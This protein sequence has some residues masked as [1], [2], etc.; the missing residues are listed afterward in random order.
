MLK[1]RACYVLVS[2]CVRQVGCADEQKRLNL[3]PKAGRGLLTAAI[4]WGFLACVE[5]ALGAAAGQR[6]GHERNP[7]CGTSRHGGGRS[8]H[9]HDLDAG[10]NQP[11]AASVRPVAHRRQQPDGTP[12]VG[13]ERGVFWRLDGARSVAAGCIRCAMRTAFAPGHRLVFPSGRTGTHPGHH[14]R[15]RRRRGGH[16]ICPGVARMKRSA[17]PCP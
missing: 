1:K 7:D 15:R 17:R 11:G 6:H 5:G 2:S 16:G 9:R 13:S 14:P 3:F 8:R 12:L 4:F 10:A